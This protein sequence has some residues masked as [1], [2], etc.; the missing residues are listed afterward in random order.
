MP[1]TAPGLYRD[2]PETDY[3]ADPCPDPSL[4]RSIAKIIAR[5][6]PRHAFVAHPR[7]N[8]DY[9][10]KARSDVF[11]L[12]T[13][14]HT[15][16]LN[17]GQGIVPAPFDDWRTN[18]AKEFREQARARGVVPLLTEQYDR[19]D[20]MRDAIMAQLPEH[21][22]SHLFDHAKGD[23]EVMAACID[24]V[25]GWS[26]ILIDWLTADLEIWDL[27]TTDIDL[28][29]EDGSIG[30]YCSSQ[31][32]EWQHAFYERTMLNLYPEME[33]RLK[34]RFLICEVKP[35]FQIYPVE[36]PNDALAKGRDAVAK[37][38]AKWASAKKDGTWPRAVTG[39]RRV[40]YPDWAVAE[41]LDEVEG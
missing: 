22:L 29:W 4:S 6:S 12:G 9:G 5:K 8:P 20:T 32:F 31:G 14:C 10:K 11:D 15:A 34:F 3:H 13:A 17:K 30:R 23:S 19:V 25:A 7:L 35:P 40:D 21:G 24:P 39:V 2:F 37:A 41:F 16:V 26:R 36:L 28:S 38:C 18:A 33:G 1:I 27:K